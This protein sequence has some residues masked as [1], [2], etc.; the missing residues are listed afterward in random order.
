MCKIC[1]YGNAD[2]NVGKQVNTFWISP[3]WQSISVGPKISKSSH[4]VLHVYIHGNPDKE[5]G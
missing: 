5:M 3:N 2:K 4:I 1:K